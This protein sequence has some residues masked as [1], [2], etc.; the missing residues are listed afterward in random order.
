MKKIKLIIIS[1]VF[2]VCFTLTPLVLGKYSTTLPKKIS[3][4]ISKVVNVAE[5]NSVFYSTLQEAIDAVPTDGTLTVVTLLSDTTEA[6]TVSE[7]QN[8]SFNLQSFSV[9]AP[10]SPNNLAVIENNGT[11]QISS[12]TLRS[13]STST[14]AVVNNNAKGTFTITGG[15]II[16]TG[17]KQALYNNGGVVNIGGNAYLSA[18]SSNRAAVQNNTGS[19]T[20]TGGTLVSPNYYGLDNKSASMIIGTKDGD[21]D[22]D[23]LLIQGKTYGVNSTKNFKYYDGTIKGTKSAINDVSKINDLETNCYVTYTSEVID[24]KTYQV[25][26]LDYGVTVTFDPNG[27]TVSEGTRAVQIG[28]AIGTLPSA[29]KNLYSFEGWFTERD[30]GTKITSSTIINDDVTY[31]AHWS[32]K[33]IAEINGRIYYTLQSAIDATP[34]NGTLTTIKL[35]MDTNENVTVYK[36]RNVVIDLQNYTLTNAGSNPTIRNNGTLEITGGT[37]NQTSAYAAIDNETT[38]TLV[39]TD[40]NISST[41]GRAAIFNLGDGNVTISGNTYL[42]SNASGE[43]K[44]DEVTMDR[45]T[46]M[47]VNN[48]GIITITGGTV[49]GTADLAVSNNGTLVLGTM[50]DGTISISEPLIKGE[51]YGLKN[52]STFN[53]YDGVIKGITGAIDGTITAQEANTQVQTDSEVIDGNTYVVNYLN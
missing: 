12:G 50:N 7:G 37:I 43:F 48:T 34:N 19:M 22:P 47:N 24:G 53:F 23:S 38:G 17:T 51:S 30:G 26:Y 8:I 4:N 36:S 16:S 39:I 46:I 9:T 3:L 11:I 2:L 1:I 5:V 41:G 27:G 10:S 52:Y 28:Q 32:Q 6:V 42:S 21:S 29:T 14:V 45:G 15:E 49:V 31:F 18:T 40:V 44:I 35:L 33:N 13:A 25:A 20:I